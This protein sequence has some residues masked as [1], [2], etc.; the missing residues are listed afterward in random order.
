MNI[1][2]YSA[3]T[4]ED[5]RIREQQLISKGYRFVSKTDEKQLSE[6]EYMKNS[7]Y[8]SADSFD[9]PRRWNIVARDPD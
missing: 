1:K 9:G 4:D 7:Y 3:M 8:G 6:Y 5:L 2:R